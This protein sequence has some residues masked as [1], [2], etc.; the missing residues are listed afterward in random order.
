MKN[1]KTLKYTNHSLLRA[2]QRGCKFQAMG[3]IHDHGSST[4]IRDGAKS[5]Y[6]KRKDLPYLRNEMPPS[7][8]NRLEK[9]LKKALVVKTSLYRDFIL[10]VIHPSRRLWN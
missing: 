5:F 2:Q 4:H 6:I 9:S 10:T 3:F 7:E 8:F 1:K